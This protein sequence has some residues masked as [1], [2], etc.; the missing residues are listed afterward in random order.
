MSFEGVSQLFQKSVA[1]RHGVA[2]WGATGGAGV[3]KR[4]P[5]IV[6]SCDAFGMGKQFG[7]ADLGFMIAAR[8]Q[9]AIRPLDL[10][11]I[12]P[13]NAGRDSAARFFAAFMSGQVWLRDEGFINPV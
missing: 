10:Y 3:P 7:M 9:V 5:R 11:A 1:T 4:E 12:Y 13:A 6:M 2:F 8:A